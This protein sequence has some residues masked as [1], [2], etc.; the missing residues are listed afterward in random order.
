M[1]FLSNIL[2]VS[3]SVLLSG[4]F[5]L[6]PECLVS[7]TP[8]HV[9][10]VSGPIPI[11]GGFVWPAIG[12]EGIYLA[13]SS[14]TGTEQAI[15]WFSEDGKDQRVYSF[16]G[17]RN[18][19]IDAGDTGEAVDDQ[20]IPGGLAVMMVWHDKKSALTGYT[21]EEFTQSGDYRN[22]IQVPS[23]Y[24][25]MH[26]A[27]FG[28]GSYLLLGG[29][30]GTSGIKRE[31]AIILDSHGTILSHHVFQQL[32][33]P[34]EPDDL[35]ANARLNAKAEPGGLASTNSGKTPLP[36]KALV[37][38]DKVSMMQAVQGGEGY[39][40]LGDEETTG[41]V[42]RVSHLGVVEECKMELPPEIEHQ[43]TVSLGMEY[44]NRT[45]T[46]LVGTVD[47]HP[48]TNYVLK[49]KDKYILTYSTTTGDL[50]RAYQI[51]D[52]RVSYIPVD[53]VGDQPRF[54]SFAKDPTTGSRRVTI[55]TLAP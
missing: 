32:E 8:L 55:V 6:V 27:G 39:V 51:Q 33:H 12:N 15:H 38:Y 48:E 4:C 23:D 3:A 24:I 50:L 54:L 35:A 11:P 22:S 44:G 41:K 1:R 31:E 29:A 17:I 52:D 20:A 18:P 28:D 2:S 16:T 30:P 40:Y 14:Y 5:A 47:P 7:Q 36:T 21:I 45:L 53:L 19:R 43:H 42:Y 34:D 49:V 26:F 46:R 10:D 9:H 13:L 25:P 37:L